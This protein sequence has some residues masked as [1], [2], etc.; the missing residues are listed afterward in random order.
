[1]S[2]GWHMTTCH[3]NLI[4]GAA[5]LDFIKSFEHFSEIFKSIHLLQP[6]KIGGEAAKQ[7]MGLYLSLSLLN[8]HETCRE[9]F[10][11]KYWQNDNKFPCQL[12]LAGLLGPPHRC[13]K[14]YF[15]YKHYPWLSPATP[16]IMFQ[17]HI[18][19]CILKQMNENI[20]AALRSAKPNLESLYK[21]ATFLS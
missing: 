17:M 4:V 11:Q 8:F 21:S 5:I 13:L 2:Q 19:T 20:Q 1:M 14:L 16:F 15:R 10:Q 18:M 9:C 12:C 7:E 6:I 3:V